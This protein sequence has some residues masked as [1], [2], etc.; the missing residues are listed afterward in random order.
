MNLRNYFLLSILALALSNA[1]VAQDSLHSTLSVSV[2]INKISNKDL[3]QSPYTYRGIA[4]RINAVYSNYTS[5]GKHTV[6]LMYSGGQIRSSISPQATNH[7]LLLNYDYLFNIRLTNQKVNV[8]LGVG[9]HTFLAQTNYLPKIASPITYS[10][11]GAYLTL[12]GQISYQMSKKSRLNLL[13]GLSVFGV[14]YRPDFEIN[15]KTL[16]KTALPGKPNLF[17]T[18]LDY[19]YTLTSKL[20][21]ITTY[22]YSFFT[23]NEPRPI[24]ILQNSLLLGLKKSF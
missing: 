13:A 17:C 24:V 10:T 8:S 9:I 20:S 14:T 7:L 22:T 21:V 19:S 5:K 1:S 11:G 6:D 4:P 23:Y 2:G 18:R 3:F 16:T 12:G 15:G